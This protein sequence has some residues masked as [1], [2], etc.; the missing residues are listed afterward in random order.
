MTRPKNDTDHLDLK[1]KKTATRLPPG[2]W[3]NDYCIRIDDPQFDR[4]YERFTG[5]FYSIDG[6]DKAHAI[7][8]F[9]MYLDIVTDW[10]DLGFALFV[11]SR[12]WTGRFKRV[13]NLA[14][15]TRHIF[16]EVITKPWEMEKVLREPRKCGLVLTFRQKGLS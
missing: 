15:G 8:H 6:E 14:K 5:T 11:R 13:A 1:T 2:E 7:K 9:K 10:K 16:P 3:V 4:G 12:M